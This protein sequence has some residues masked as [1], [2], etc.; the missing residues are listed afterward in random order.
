MNFIL[1]DKIKDRLV[2]NSSTYAS[3]GDSR[4]LAGAVERYA[5]GKTLDMG[6]GTGIQGIVAAKKGCTVTF[7][8]KNPE[9][10]KC[11]RLNAKLNG[12]HGTFVVSDLFSDVKGK[13]NT[14]VFDPPYLRS[15]LIPKRLQNSALHGGGI[16]GRGVM[17]RFLADYAAHVLEDHRVLLV[18]PPW[19]VWKKDVSVL[20]AEVVAKT[21][22]PLL[23]DFVV[24]MF[25]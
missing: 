8:D 25:E 13:F 16:L 6:S 18:E 4:L 1:Y 20:N 11:S 19:A 2:V 7:A 3:R 23:G 10:V 9:A 5:F 22:Y 14:I 12:V 21:H 24:L 15:F 17:D